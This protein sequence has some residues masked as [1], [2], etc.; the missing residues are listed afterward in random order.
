MGFFCSS[1][2]R[3]NIIINW[4]IFKDLPHILILWS[5]SIWLSIY[6]D[7]DLSPKSDQS[8]LCLL[9]LLFEILI[10]IH[11][12][13]EFIAAG[14]KIL[15]GFR[16]LWVCFIGYLSTDA[17][18]LFFSLLSR[19]VISRLNSWLCLLAWL[20]RRWTQ[21]IKS[22]FGIIAKDQINTRLSLWFL[23]HMLYYI[24]LNN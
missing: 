5:R 10:L 22:S 13:I 7:L 15:V 1:V 20:V 21:P 3:I 18:M 16:F 11:Q 17:F 4:A 14:S 6:L 12:F 9:S 19:L 8:R 2:Y 23:L 24:K